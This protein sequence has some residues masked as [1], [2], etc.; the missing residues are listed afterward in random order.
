MRK[1]DQFPEEEPE[2]T[3]PD[4]PKHRGPS[5]EELMLLVFSGPMCFECLDQAGEETEESDEQQTA[6]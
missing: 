2:E 3:E 6:D 5:F 4:V 1:P